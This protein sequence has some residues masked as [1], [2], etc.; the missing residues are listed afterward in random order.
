M[1][2]SIGGAFGF[3]GGD[4]GGSSLSRKQLIKIQD[5]KN[6]QLNTAQ[7]ELDAINKGKAWDK[8][9]ASFTGPVSN[10]NFQESLRGYF[11]GNNFED[12]GKQIAENN[13]FLPKA[14]P[15]KVKKEESDWYSG[16]MQPPTLFGN[17]F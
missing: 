6:Q 10:Q 2:E 7:A 13:A 15:L 8:F 14:K 5:R 1:G 4:N 12:I 17:L 16:F 9:K 11:G 3:G